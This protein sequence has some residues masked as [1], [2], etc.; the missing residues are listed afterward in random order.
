MRDPAMRMKENAE[1]ETESILSGAKLL[2]GPINC[3]F[4]DRHR[5]RSRLG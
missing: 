2:A 4:R 5:H 1:H 3:S